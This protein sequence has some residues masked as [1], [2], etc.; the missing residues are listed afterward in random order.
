MLERR[1]AALAR[2]QEN[3]DVSQVCIRDGGLTYAGGYQAALDLMSTSRLPD[4]LLCLTDIMALGAMDAV[5]FE[6]HLK[7]PDDVAVM[8]F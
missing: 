8:G 1:Q 7:I 6:L 5:R 2:L 4:S 3:I